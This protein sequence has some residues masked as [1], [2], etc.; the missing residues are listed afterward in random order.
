MALLPEQI[1]A[2]DGDLGINEKVFYSIKL[3]KSFSFH[4]DILKIFLL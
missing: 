3:G 4:L 1:F 2:A